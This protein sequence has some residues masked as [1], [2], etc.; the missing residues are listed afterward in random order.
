MCDRCNRDFP[1]KKDLRD[2]QR[3]P[4]EQMCDV[5][6]HDP[7]SG[8]DG[9]TM[10]KLLSRK[11]ASGMSTEVQWKEIWNLLFPDDDDYR[12]QP[13]GMPYTPV[14]HSFSNP[15]VLTPTRLLPRN[16]AFRVAE[17][18]HEQSERRRG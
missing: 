4:K 11:R 9:P 6:D 17:P 3:L 18:V 1:S 7:E 5:S 15:K 13:F 2:H 14:Q 8:I 12:V 16:R 10:T